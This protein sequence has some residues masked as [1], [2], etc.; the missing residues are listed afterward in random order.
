MTEVSAWIDRLEAALISVDEHSV[1]AIINEAQAS[2]TP[3]DCAERAIS[4][5]LRR[6]GVGWQKG[7]ASL[8]QVY[9]G[10]K[11]CEKVLS[12]LQPAAH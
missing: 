3:L 4:P 6:I 9:L 5:T 12:R 1:N 8:S 2:M 10:G 7:R 11:T